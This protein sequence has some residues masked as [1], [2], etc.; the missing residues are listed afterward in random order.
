RRVVAVEVA[1]AFADARATGPAGREQVQ[2][3][4]RAPRVGVGQ[5]FADARDPGVE[6]EAVHVCQLATQRARQAQVEEAVGAHRAADVEQQQQSR[7]HTT[8][9][10]PGEAQR[11][12]AAR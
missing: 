3:L 8:V 12:A 9:L 11:C 6:D 10:L 7:A 1:Q 4:L 5:R 2:P